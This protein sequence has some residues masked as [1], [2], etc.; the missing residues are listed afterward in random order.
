MRFEGRHQVGQL[1]RIEDI[2]F[3]RYA[4]FIG[5]IVSVHPHW[6]GKETLDNI[7]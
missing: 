5:R 3:S 1:V 4:G 7:R 6:R 2:I